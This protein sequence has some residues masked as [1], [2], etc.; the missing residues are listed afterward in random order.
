MQKKAEE[1]LRIKK[2]IDEL[3]Y[4][5]DELKTFMK[6]ELTK[7]GVEE[8]KAGPYTISNK[9]FS[10]S[11]FDTTAF[12]NGNPEVYEMYLKESTQTRF[13]VK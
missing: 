3:N 10:S 4:Q 9:G 11:R 7:R 12:K 8:L 2:E 13:S 1:Y 6:D 5:L